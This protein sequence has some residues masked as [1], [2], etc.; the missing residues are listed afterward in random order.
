MIIWYN[1]DIFEI[2]DK[3]IMYEDIYEKII[4]EEILIRIKEII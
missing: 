4:K 1:G 3:L 2:L